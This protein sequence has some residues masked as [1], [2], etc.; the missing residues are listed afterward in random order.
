MNKERL[1]SKGVKSVWGLVAMPVLCSY[2]PVCRRYS[3]SFTE[4]G[5]DD[6]GLLPGALAKGLD[7]ATRMDFA[8]AAEVAS[9][10]GLP[11]SSSGVQRL[12]QSYG[13]LAW[14]AGKERL[15]RLE[16]QPLESSKGH[17]KGRHIVIE[18]DGTYVLEREK[19]KDGKL[20]GREVKSIVIYPLNAPK[21]RVSVSA[22]VTIDASPGA[23]FAAASW[24]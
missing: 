1:S 5:M 21:E 18:I 14:E 20:E 13:E 19:G 24:D 12:T 16:Q 23:R 7:L 15:V 4:K 3:R 6:S 2:C 11:L 9:Q 8:D 17:A 10:W 22:P